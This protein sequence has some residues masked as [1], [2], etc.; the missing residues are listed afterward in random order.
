M[1]ELLT[2][3]ELAD[4]LKR[5]RTYVTAMRRRGFPMPGS[6]ATLPNALAWLLEHPRPRTKTKL[7][8]RGSVQRTRNGGFF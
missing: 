5:H 2:C 3:D 4:V 1:N 8:F 7:Q 6:R